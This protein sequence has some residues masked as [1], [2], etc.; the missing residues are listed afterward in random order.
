M[1]HA[2]RGPTRICGPCGPQISGKNGADRGLCGPGFVTTGPF[3]ICGPGFGDLR[4]GVGDLRTV[5]R[6]L[7][8]GL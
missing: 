7:R 8:T 5:V 1:L 3:E 2:D 4:T 6:D